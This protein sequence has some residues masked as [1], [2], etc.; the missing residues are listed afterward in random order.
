MHPLVAQ[1]V[2]S[3]NSRHGR[4]LLSAV[5]VAEVEDAIAKE[6]VNLKRIDFEIERLFAHRGSNPIPMEQVREEYAM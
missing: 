1:M 6:D 5:T 3:V 4:R 2:L